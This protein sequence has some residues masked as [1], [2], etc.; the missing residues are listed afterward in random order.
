MKR[1]QEVT[2]VMQP[3]PG[4]VR[5]VL[6]GWLLTALVMPALA[7]GSDDQELWIE[8]TDAAI[9]VMSGADASRVLQ[10]PMEAVAFK[11]QRWQWGVG[12]LLQSPSQMDSRNALVFEARY[13]ASSSWYLLA[14]LEYG[15]FNDELLSTPAGQP[16]IAAQ[17]SASVIA[18]GVGLSLL[19]GTGQLLNGDIRPWQISLELLAGEQYTGASSGRYS[20]AGLGWQMLG[21]E[22]W[23]GLDWRV[24]KVDDSLLKAA[25]VDQ[26]MQ[27]SVL[28]G[29]YF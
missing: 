24:Y 20:A 7:E 25:G 8:D 19:R 13:L 29:R 18:A 17:Q 21:N 10:N 23:L 11:V 15:R 12:G 28:L 14:N 27:G 22:W 1:V 6:L 16:V 5:N 4:L 2:D 3:L 9:Q 26:G